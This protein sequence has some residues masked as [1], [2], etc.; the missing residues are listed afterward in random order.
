M[1]KDRG[2]FGWMTLHV[3]EQRDDYPAARSMDG[4]MKIVDTGKMRVSCALNKV[5]CMSLKPFERGS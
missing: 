3:Q 5:I 4:A 2:R 1:D